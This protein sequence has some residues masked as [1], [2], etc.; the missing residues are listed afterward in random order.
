MAKLVKMNPTANVDP[1]E[2]DE[3]GNDHAAMQESRNRDAA[4]KKEANKKNLKKS[5]SDKLGGKRKGV[6]RY[7]QYPKDVD[8]DGSGHYINFYIHS[9][10]AGKASGS[11]K[12]IA[13]LTSGTAT[14]QENVNKGGKAKAHRKTFY[15][16]SPPRRLLNTA[17]SLYMPAQVTTAY[18]ATYQ[19]KEIGIG[20]EA[21]MDGIRQASLI[22]GSDSNEYGTTFFDKGFGGVMAGL[23]TLSGAAPQL[24]TR[25][26]SSVPG[27]TG[28]DALLG[29]GTG[30]VS[31]NRMELLFE[32]MNRRTFSY[33]FTFVP[34]TETEAKDIQEIIFMFKHG[35]HPELSSGYG[36]SN[37]PIISGAKKVVQKFSGTT[38][39][40]PKGSGTVKPGRFFKMPDTFDIEYMSYG[41][42]N[43][44]IHKI[45]TCYCENVSVNY[46]GDKFRAYDITDGMEWPGSGGSGAPPQTIA[47]TVNFKEV[48]FLN[49]SHIREGY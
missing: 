4:R 1:N 10:T 20:T 33:T 46:G 44:F 39:K 45:S 27:M 36:D 19:D 9:M 11:S 13:R 34:Q 37:N 14:N 42:V 38:D 24:L 23:K 28:A 49:K 2:F 41:K 31:T 25:A 22:S 30:V 43:N 6:T 47:L 29:L 16:A 35:M 7:L 3:F 8:Q 15:T 40:G 48:E 26:L 5:S 18:G 17:I 12:Q 32:R 21:I